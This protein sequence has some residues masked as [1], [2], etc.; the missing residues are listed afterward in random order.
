MFLEKYVLSSNTEYIWLDR[1]EN[2]KK[3]YISD[4]LT[5]SKIDI[6]INN[7]E[8]HIK[9]INKKLKHIDSIK[10]AIL[11]GDFDKKK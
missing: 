5:S 3:T 7:V 11:D 4:V 1:S 8:F 2:L 10:R 6:I 9:K